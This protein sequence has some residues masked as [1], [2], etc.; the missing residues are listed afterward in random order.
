MLDAPTARTSLDPT[1]AAHPA[2]NRTFR[3]PSARAALEAIREAFGDDGIIVETREVNTDAGRAVEIVA[4]PAPIEPPPEP[5]RASAPVTVD[6]QRRRRD[7]D[8]I[9]RAER[10]GTAPHIA[11]SIVER[12]SALSRADPLVALTSAIDEVIETETAPWLP[13]RKRRVAALV[14]PTGVGKTTTVAKIAARAL[15]ES[16]MEVVLITLDTW[17]IGAADHI[18]RYG[19]IMSVPTF[20]ASDETSFMEAIERTR[21]AELVLVDTSGWSPSEAENFR[22]QIA[23][24]QQV[25]DIEIHIA[26]SA[27]SSVPQLRSVRDR[28]AGL[29]GLRTLVTKVD[30]AEGLGGII[31]VGAILGRTVSAFTDGQ[32]VPEDLH[33]ID[34]RALAQQLLSA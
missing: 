7:K 33:V 16:E 2:G 21:R 1:A 17:R 15:L 9:A 26:V 32:R 10:I 27:A 34:T 12:A 24:L 20:V 6:R 18:R 31:N 25:P 3:A 4:R 30:E 28:Y 19:E 14:G 5:P 11:R 23:L 8:V 22:R 13:G 29:E